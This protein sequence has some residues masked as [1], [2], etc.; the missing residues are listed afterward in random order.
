MSFNKQKH[1]L[2]AVLDW[3]LGHATRCIPVINCLLANKCKVSVAGNGPSLTLLR[4]EFPQLTFHELSPYQVTYPS[5]GFFFLHLL[6]QSPRIFLA[7]R[8]ER[9]QIEKLVDENQIDAII[10]DNRY[11]CY[12]DKVPSVLISHQ[13]NIQLPSS[14]AWS[15]VMVDFLNHGLIKKFAVCW[16]PDFPSS[17]FTGKLS[18]TRQLKVRYVGMLSRFAPNEEVVKE[19]LVVGLVSGPEPQREIF[20]KLLIREFRKLNQPSLIVRG[21]PQQMPKETRDGDIT[22]VAHAPTRDMESII[23]KAGFIISRSG[24]STIMDL[25]ALSK[26]RV[27]F[28]PTPGQSEQEYLAEELKRR[29]IAYSQNQD[30]FILAE[31]IQKSMYYHGFDTSDHHTNLLNEAVQDLLHLI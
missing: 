29:K 1:I 9:K 8:N 26:K 24:Y 3:G 17:G 15:K 2:V 28:V 4:K 13:L 11:G 12:S 14:L 7:I 16:I 25:Q 30:Q 10:S 20:E 31:A 21:L 23:S 6:F 19:D 22:L 18:K 5:N 27:I